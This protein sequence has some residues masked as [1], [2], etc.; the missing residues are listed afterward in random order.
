[1]PRARLTLGRK[2]MMTK[3]CRPCVQGCPRLSVA[4]TGRVCPETVEGF[5]LKQRTGLLRAKHCTCLQEACA[6]LVSTSPA[7]PQHSAFQYDSSKLYAH[8]VLKTP[9]PLLH[10]LSPI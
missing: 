1:M 10:T 2:N 9:L 3:Q 8:V 6:V 5:D 7:H 4:G